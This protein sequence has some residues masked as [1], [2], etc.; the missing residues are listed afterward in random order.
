MDT[1]QPQALSIR[2]RCI[3]LP[4]R[5]L[6]GRSQIRLGIQK[7]KDAI[8]DVLAD[9]VEVVFTCSV[10]VARNEATGKPIFLGPYAQG[11]P[12]ERFLYLCWGERN[13]GAWEG[14]GRAKVHLKAIEWAT[15]EHAITTG[16][17]L[18]AT[19]KMTDKKGGPL[20][21]SVP[22]DHITWHL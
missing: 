1:N 17:P 5:E 12:S 19:I 9:A 18:E 14:I 10:R 3:D 11:T 22:S 16:H 4:G 20:C 15:V 6:K 7:G 13:A 8:E 2:L 21:A